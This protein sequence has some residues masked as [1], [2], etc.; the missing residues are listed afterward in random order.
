MATKKTTSQAKTSTSPPEPIIQDIHGNPYEVVPSRVKRFWYDHPDGSVITELLVD[1]GTRI[2]TKTEVR[3]DKDQVIPSGVGHAEEVRGS[4]NVNNT[5]A[6]ENAETSSTG[7]ALGLAGYDGSNHSIAT[8]EEVRSAIEQQKNTP[9]KPVK[10]AA[11]KRAPA[12]TP[13]ETSGSGVPMYNV[14]N[15]E[16]VEITRKSDGATFTK[17]VVHTGEGVKLETFNEKL[18][19]TA[20]S[21]LNTGVQITAEHEPENNYGSCKLKDLQLTSNAPASVDN[22][23]AMVPDDDDIPF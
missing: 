23:P 11:T 17:F 16:S 15:V 9:A 8:A 7:R 18:R 2:V 22:E 1:D 20:Q 3:F 5:S 10:K 4:S 6:L 21:A 13:V 14:T 12:P 19:D